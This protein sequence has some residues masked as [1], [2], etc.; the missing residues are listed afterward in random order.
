MM[1]IEF[2]RNVLGYKD[3]NSSEMDPTTPHNVI[4]IMDGESFEALIADQL[5]LY[6]DLVEE[7]GLKI[8]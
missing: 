6:G 5:A 8:K 2:A 7:L 1:V 4:D 3:A